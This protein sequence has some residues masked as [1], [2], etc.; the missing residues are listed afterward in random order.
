[1]RRQVINLARLMQKLC[2]VLDHALVFYCFIFREEES[3]KNGQT[4]YLLILEGKCKKLSACL[5]AIAVKKSA[6]LVIVSPLD[7][8]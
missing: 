6:E 2:H 5:G 7:A 8:S 3:E 1:M 4:L